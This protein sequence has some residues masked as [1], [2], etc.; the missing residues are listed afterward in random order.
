M[1]LPKRQSDI[2]ATKCYPSSEVLL[3][4]MKIHTKWKFIEATLSFISM[5]SLCTVYCLSQARRVLTLCYVY[6]CMSKYPS[7]KYH[8]YYQYRYRK[9]SQVWV[10]IKYGFLKHLASQQPYM[11]SST[12]ASSTPVDSLNPSDFAHSILL[13]AALRS[14]EQRQLIQ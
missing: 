10:I 14:K 11:K 8:R 6:K 9:L 5:M 2:Q 3:G 4:N 12:L 7:R 13:T 1:L